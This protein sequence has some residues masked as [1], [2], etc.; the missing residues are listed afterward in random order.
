MKYLG[1]LLQSQPSLPGIASRDEL[2]ALLADLDMHPSSHKASLEVRCC[3]S[4]VTRQVFFRLW[5]L[6]RS[7]SAHLIPK[8]ML[9]GACKISEGLVVSL[10]VCTDVKILAVKSKGVAND[11]GCEPNVWAVGQS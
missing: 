9:D 3:M 5:P 8:Q 11:T 10:D 6:C 4:P 2:A 7:A 1:L